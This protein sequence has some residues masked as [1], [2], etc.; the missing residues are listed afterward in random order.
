M[1]RIRSLS[2]RYGKVP[3]FSAFDLDVAEREVVALMGPSGAGK[4]TVLRCMNGLEP[5]DAGEVTIA[6]RALPSGSSREQQRVAQALRADV[7]LVFQAGHLFAHRT[8]LENVTEAPIHVRRLQRFAAEKDAKA[9]LER[10]G[11]GHRMAAYPHE[12]SGGEVQRVAVAR[13]LAMAPKV[14]LLDEPTSALNSENVETLITMLRELNSEGLTLVVVTHD[15]R[16]APALGARV[17]ELSV[18]R[19]QVVQP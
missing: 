4:S 14:L 9:L 16:V 1:I 8:V 15:A 17:V 7:G 10:F 18:P 5:F 11:V 3:L 12:L 19:T 2:K 13:A 6:G